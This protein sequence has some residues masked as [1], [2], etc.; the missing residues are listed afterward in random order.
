MLARRHPSGLSL[1]RSLVICVQLIK[2]VDTRAICF[3]TRQGLDER[4]RVQPD[5]ESPCWTAG[6]CFEFLFEDPGVARMRFGDGSG[7]SSLLKR[8]PVLDYDE[9]GHLDCDEVFLLYAHAAG[10]KCFLVTLDEAGTGGSL[11]ATVNRRPSMAEIWPY[12]TPVARS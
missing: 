5:H 10:S 6:D 3:H 8:V 1:G 7:S 4:H 12:C 11:S 9:R 2:S